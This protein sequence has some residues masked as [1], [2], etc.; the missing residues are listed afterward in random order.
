MGI[1][2]LS[3]R[4]G[5]LA[6]GLAVV[7][8]CLVLVPVQADAAVQCPSV[9][10]STGVVSPAPQAN[11][12]WSG[13]D[14]AGAN[15]F[16]YPLTN[17]NL[18]DANLTGADFF[19]DHI[20]GGDLSHANLTSANLGATKISADATDADFSDANLSG[21][22]L[23]AATISGAIMG[24]ATITGIRTFNTKGVPASLPSGWEDIDL[25]ILGP[26]ARAADVILEGADLAGLDLDQADLSGADLE[27]TNLAGTDLSSASLDAVQSGGV[28]GT[29]SLPSGWVLA[30]GYLV[31]PNADLNGADLA[32]A[33]LAGMNLSVTDL[34]AANLDGTN[35]TGTDLDS[36][37]LSQANLTQAN[38]TNG[39]A[40]QANLKGAI[41]GG[42]IVTG[43]NLTD[44]DLETADLAGG[45]LDGAI[46]TGIE[47]GSITGTAVL[48]SGWLLYNGYLVG[49]SADLS[50][51]SLSGLSFSGADLH[52]TNFSGADLSSA[53]L[54]SASLAG[55]DLST[56]DLTDAN[57]DSA[58][59]TSASLNS[60]DLTGA[61]LDSATVTGTDFTNVT[62]LN[63]TCPD[64][65][66]SNAHDNGCF[67]ALD[68]T[69]PVA[70]PWLASGGTQV[71]G[72][73]NAPVTVFWGWTDAGQLPA[74][75]CTAH[76]ETK[77]SGSLT[78][79]ASC[80]DLAGNSASASYSL[81]VDTT[82][83]AVKVTGV[84]SGEHYVIG[85]V[86]AAGCATAELVSGLSADASVSVSSGGSGG[87][88][89]FTATCAGAVS[90]AGLPQKA[91]VQ[92]MYTVGYGFGG[93]ASPAAGSSVPV[94]SRHFTAAFRLVSANGKPISAAA[95]GHLA[96]GRDVRVILTGPGIR[97]VTAICGLSGR[98]KQF[99]CAIAIPAGVRTG[100]SHKYTIT[101]EENVGTKF[102]V[103]PAVGSARNPETIHFS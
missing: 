8:G 81:K 70:H 14:L 29:P 6:A 35:L 47:S 31:G 44:A 34:S 21:S 36:A 74:A 42:A 32:G 97:P 89:P 86:P 95:G 63:T 88:G 59:L 76:T 67:T 50:G 94:S 48:P 33:D 58:D 77:T 3:F 20:N 79:T 52:G 53:D 40:K 16:G 27:D 82:R 56:A 17:L 24:T 10:Q 49:A 101:A 102:Y 12:D 45:D 7:A 62:W 55:S 90:F 26:T 15:L 60:A 37:N 25:T 57:L 65:S 72:W 28:T 61:N 43:L 99:T 4:A 23:T 22:D 100:K 2:V 84:R 5:V 71:N 19:L 18:S 83:P 46:L 64:D 54:S 66:D 87:V 39:S 30:G 103:V 13:C 68:T 78:L 1:R 69:P 92:A 80:T 73:F 41:L 9:N 38:L 91:P 11:D 96:F 98:K 75:T 85:Q 93:Y 51:A